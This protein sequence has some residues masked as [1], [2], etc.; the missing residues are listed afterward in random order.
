MPRRWSA[1]VA[2]MLTATAV[3]LAGHDFWIE[4]STFHPAPGAVVGIGLRVGQGFVGDPVRRSSEYIEAFVVRQGNRED[5]VAGVD[6][7]D[8]AGV[9]VADGR[10][11]AIVAYR[12]KPAFI[13]LPADRFEEYLRL[14]GLES[15]IAFRRAHGTTGKS[16]LEYFTRYAKALLTGRSGSPAVSRPVGFHMEIVPGA[17]PTLRSGA[18][19]G[20]VLYRG[21]PL[22]GALVIAMPQSNPAER[23]MVRTDVRGA[24]TFSRLHS[25]VWLIKSVHMV[26]A[27]WFSRADWE[28]AWASLTFEVPHDEVTTGSHQP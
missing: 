17:D 28:S 4:A 5:V 2:A 7:R 26:E 6:D 20:T 27:G 10:E 22:A 25:G 1:T 23:S 11:T 21:A 16:G 15:I 19:A 18:F 24:F 3:R 9:L 13:E 14:E 12:S 8:P